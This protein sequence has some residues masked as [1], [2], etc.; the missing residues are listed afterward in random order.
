MI[1]VADRLSSKFHGCA[2]SN[3][4]FSS[5]LSASGII[6]RDKPAARRVIEFT[7]LSFLR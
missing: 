2:G 7:G 3:V 5:N 6:L 4:R 1:P